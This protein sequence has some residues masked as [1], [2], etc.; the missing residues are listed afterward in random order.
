MNP[1]V[2]TMSDSSVD[3]GGL[4]SP[5]SICSAASTIGT[6][7]EVHARSRFRVLACWVAWT[8]REKIADW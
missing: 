8:A 4:G 7:S 6:P 1:F 5:G 2:R 3:S